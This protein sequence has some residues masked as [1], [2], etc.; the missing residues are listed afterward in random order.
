V[1][2]CTRRDH[3]AHCL[4]EQA[5]NASMVVVGSHGRGAVL[6]AVVGSVS[7]AI[8]RHAQCPVVVVRPGSR[9]R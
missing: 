2:R 9:Q 3:P 4:L 6:G 7:Q 8:I 5:K 1:H